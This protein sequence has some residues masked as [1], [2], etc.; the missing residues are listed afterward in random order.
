[1]ATAKGSSDEA[2]EKF[3]MPL[4]IWKEHDLTDS[5]LFKE[6]IVRLK[7][8]RDMHVLFT[9]EGETGVGKTTAAITMCMLCDLHGFNSEKVKYE[10]EDF[11]TS[12]F[13]LPPGS[14]LL[15]DDVQKWMDSRESMSKQQREQTQDIQA[16]RVRQVF[17][18][19][20]APSKGWLEKR[21]GDIADFWVQCQEGESGEPEGEAIVYRLKREEMYEDQYTE[22][23]GS[24]SW[25]PLDDREIYQQI[26][27]KKLDWIKGNVEDRYVPKD[28]V[29]EKLE[30]VEKR[31]RKLTRAKI[32][33]GVYNYMQMDGD[34]DSLSQRKLGEA[35]GREDEDLEL[36]QQSVSNILKAESVEEYYSS[37]F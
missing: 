25:Q 20:T 21:L 32:A 6:Y 12:Y 4:E 23:M 33:R 31:T 16:N 18:A 36:S 28:E 5:E 14:W 8:N 13:N 29:E 2:G 17:V 3:D 7:N 15:A 19:W 24:F 9:G 26:E 11:N 27:Q 22:R 34:V 1:M 10:I 30:R 37:L 35:I